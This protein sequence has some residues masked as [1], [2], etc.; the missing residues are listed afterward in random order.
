MRPL[1]LSRITALAIS[2][3][4]TL[5]AAGPAL[6]DDHHT[7]RTTAPSVQAPL[8]GAAAL[9]ARTEALGQVSSVPAPVTDLLE[10]VLRADGG[11]IPVADAE[12][13][14]AE[15]E[16]AVE[17][18]K[19]AAPATSPA[20]R[21]AP[22]DVVT[23]ALAAIEKAVADLLASVTSGNPLGVIPTVTGTLTSL[24]DLVLGLLGGGLPATP[25]LPAAPSLPAAAEVPATPTVTTPG[26]PAT[27]LPA[28]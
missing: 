1:A 19:A 25:A 28:G 15:V 20:S 10:T 26:L 24:I 27:P 13:L 23:D 12:A 16:T 8:P 6:A 21:A 5:G 2:A 22:A 18:A 3:A 9:L 17:A 11:Q 4:I 14:R 7:P